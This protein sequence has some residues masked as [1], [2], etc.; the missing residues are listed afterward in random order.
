M[1]TPIAF[2]IFNRPETTERVFAAIRA[3]QPE[4]LL[5]IADGPRSNRP[6]EADRCAATRA[7]IEQV[8]WP[9]QVLTNYAAENLGCRKR[10]AS[11]LDWVFETVESAIILEDDC[12]PHPSFFDYC[13][14]LLDRYRDD[15][16]VF[17][18]TGLNVQFG[19]QRG[20]HSYYFSR[21]FHCWGWASWRRAWQQYEGDLHD[22]ETIRDQNLLLQLLGDRQTAKYWTRELEAIYRGQIDTWDHQCTLSA[23]R[24]NALHIVPNVNLVSNIG[25]GVEATNTT[26]GE[27][28]YANMPVEAIALPLNHPTHLIRHAAA[29][30]FAQTTLYDVSRWRRAVKKVK[31][32]LKW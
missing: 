13:T 23:W 5:V 21:Y 6:G 16:R 25:F 19:Q 15:K 14:E 31:R 29:D 28:A 24:Q 10:V 22:W 27:S 4:Q 7:I 30:H 17:S 3:A 9:C 20:P 11:G 2:L 12:L 26:H 1:K 18:I 32:L 8:D